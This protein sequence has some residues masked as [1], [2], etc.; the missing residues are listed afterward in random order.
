VEDISHLVGV[1]LVEPA[2]QTRILSE[3]AVAVG[4][5][6]RGRL[7]LLAVEALDA[8]HEFE[9]HSLD[10]TTLFELELLVVAELAGVEDA[11]AGGLDV[12]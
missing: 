3:P 11:A 4:A 9:L 2:L 7:D 8:G 10:L 12:A 6:Q 5:V 1:V